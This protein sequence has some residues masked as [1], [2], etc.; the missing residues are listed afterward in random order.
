MDGQQCPWREFCGACLLDFGHG[1][2]AFPGEHD[3][4]RYGP[5]E[6][7]LDCHVHRAVV[8]S[9]RQPQPGTDGGAGGDSRPGAVLLAGPH[10]ERGGGYDY[11]GCGGSC[12]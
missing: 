6:L 5:G 1:G 9:F 7:C 8:L 3:L 11:C 2:R 10:A 4:H 12:V